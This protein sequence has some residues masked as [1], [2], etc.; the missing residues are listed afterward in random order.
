[1]SERI[2]K[3]GG[4]S[5]EKECPEKF[6]D[7]PISVTASELRRFADILQA[8][9]EATARADLSSSKELNL[10]PQKGVVRF[11]VCDL[12]IVDIK[13][14][15]EQ[16]DSSIIYEI[17]GCE[18]TPNQLI[19]GRKYCLCNDTK[20]YMHVKLA[21]K[22]IQPAE[23]S[24]DPGAHIAIVVAPDKNRPGPKDCGYEIYRVG[25][26]RRGE[27]KLCSG[28]GGPKLGIVDPPG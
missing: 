4:A 25:G 24:L 6:I 10:V 7:A 27:E 5:G 17:V 19:R 26:L 28:I 9:A 22:E 20:S 2:E 18:I 11:G 12:R 1:M 16:E 3:K 15:V 14:P 13:R 8:M 23:F 21:C